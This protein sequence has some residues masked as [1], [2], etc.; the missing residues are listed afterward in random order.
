MGETCAFDKWTQAMVY[1]PEKFTKIPNV[2]LK[3]ARKKYAVPKTA[4]KLMF[5]NNGLTSF[6]L[7]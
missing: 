7:D 3:F 4:K 6:K 1:G 5:I 2:F